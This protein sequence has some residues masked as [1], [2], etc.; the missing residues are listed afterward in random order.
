[1]CS[2]SMP[3][4]DDFLQE[5]SANW[6]EGRIQKVVL[7]EI[8]PFLF[9][10]IP[11]ISLTIKTPGGHLNGNINLFEMYS[12]VIQYT[13]N[14]TWLSPLLC[15]RPFLYMKP[16]AIS[17]LLLIPLVPNHQKP[18]ICCPYGHVSSGYCLQMDE[19]S[20]QSPVRLLPWT[21]ILRRNCLLAYTSASFLSMAE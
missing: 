17:Q 13:Q 21:V 18:L 9:V 11:K 7:Q 19:Y 12:S 8:K 14:S 6:E 10:F 15:P 16:V 3:K 2:Q 20:T 1:M 5:S 4:K